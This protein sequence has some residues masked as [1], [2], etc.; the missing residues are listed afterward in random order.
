MKHDRTRLMELLAV[1]CPLTLEAFCDA[2]RGRFG[3]PD[4]EFDSENETEWGLVE[5]DGIEYNVSRP[6]ERG[7]LQK[8]DDS[9]PAGCNFGVT[10]IVSKD[11]PPYQD[12]EWSSAELVP[13]IGQGLADLLG[14]RVYHHRSW[15]GVGD[16]VMQRRV[17]HPRASRK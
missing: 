14:Q 17:F 16:N 5:R 6:Y 10:L 11:C 7:T 3:L 9:V 15:V 2:M 12:V 1:D 8:W 4:F 13:N